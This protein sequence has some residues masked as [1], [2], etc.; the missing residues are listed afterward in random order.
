VTNPSAG[1]WHYEYAIHNRNLDRA[2]QSF[3][4]PLGAGITVTNLEFHA[5][6]NPAGFANDGTQN[7]AGFSNAA[8]TSNQTADALT[9]NSETFA[10]NQNANAIR[11]GTLYNFSFDSPH[12]FLIT[13]PATIGFFKTGQPITVDVLVPVPGGDT[14]TYPNATNAATPRQ[15]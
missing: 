10:E 7:N 6:L 2:I 11:W 12:E 1:V 9:W 4:V 8:W 5:P 14:D 15:R 3:S 13:A